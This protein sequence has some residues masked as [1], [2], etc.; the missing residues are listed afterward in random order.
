[1]ASATSAMPHVGEC[2]RMSENIQNHWQFWMFFLPRRIQQ[3]HFVMLQRPQ[4]RS[5]LYASILT[6]QACSLAN[7]KYCGIF[8]SSVKGPSHGTEEF[9]KVLD[10]FH[11]VSRSARSRERRGLSQ[12]T[13]DCCW[14]CAKKSS[15]TTD[16]RL[17]SKMH[18]TCSY[19]ITLKLH[20]HH[21]KGVKEFGVVLKETIHR[22]TPRYTEC[23]EES[24]SP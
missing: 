4:A 2:R 17:Y 3:F 9:L 14:P 11:L 7:G 24:Q 22:D 21:D 5:R 18:S 20:T 13:Y 10:L 23:V 6:S 15:G 8:L 12:G 1:M 19:A 16:K